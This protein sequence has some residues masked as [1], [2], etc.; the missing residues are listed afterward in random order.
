MAYDNREQIISQVVYSV[1]IFTA[2]ISGGT[3]SSSPANCTILPNCSSSSLPTTSLPILPFLLLYYLCVGV[4]RALISFCRLET[5]HEL[6]LV[7]LLNSCHSVHPWL[8]HSLFFLLVIPELLCNIS[9][10][11]ASSS[12]SSSPFKSNGW[13]LLESKSC[14]TN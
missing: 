6:M 3:Y 14:A 1:T 10:N 5:T 2:G 12:S 8:C 7:S 11:A 13:P 9:L 4:E